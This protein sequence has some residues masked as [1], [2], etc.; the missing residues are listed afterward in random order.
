MSRPQAPGAEAFL[1]ARFGPRTLP[2]AAQKCQGCELYR[3]ATQAVFGEGPRDASLMLIGEQPGD[4]EDQGGRPFIGPAGR[5][6]DR[7][8][9]EVGL[10]RERVYLTN[11]VKHFRFQHRG[12]RRIHQRPTMGQTTACRPWLTAELSMIEPDG[13]VLLGSLAGQSLFGGDYRVGD[14]R[15]QF[16]ELPDSTAWA[17]PTIHPS[18]ALRAEDRDAVYAGLVDDLRL[19]AERLESAPDNG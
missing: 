16:V 12:K 5:L 9:A 1:P 17:L 7:A 2:A 8:L 18:A 11:A 15:G 6:L 4:V 3:D 10:E 13:V 14:H 19:A